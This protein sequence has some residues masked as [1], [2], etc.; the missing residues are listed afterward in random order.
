MKA[1]CLLLCT[2]LSAAAASAAPAHGR[3]PAATR[4]AAKP[5]KP[6][7]RVDAVAE[8]REAP[9]P[10]RASPGQV[11]SVTADAAFFDRG[12]ADGVTVGQELTF[13][14]GG[15]AAGKCT[16]A[17]V[18][19]HFARCATM[20]LRVGDRVGV[21]RGVA[22]APVAPAPLPSEAELLRRAASFDDATWRLRAFEGGRGLGA[23]AATRAELLVSHTTYG[24]LR[25]GN[26]AFGVQRLDAAVY[27]VELWRGLRASADVTVLNFSARP[28]TPNVGRPATRT[29]YQRSPVLL[30]RQLELSFRRA[31]VPFFAA[32]GRTWL[33]G[34]TG[35]MVLDGAQAGWRFGEGLELGAYGGLLPQAARLEVTPSQWAAG[36]FGRARFS[37][38]TGAG[39]TLGQLGVRAG[40]AQR[41]FAGEAAPVQRGEVTLTGQLWA[42]A[43]FDAATSLEFGFGDKMAPA[44]L[45][46]ARVDLGWRPTDAWRVVGGVRYRGLPL[47]G[48]VEVGTVSPGQRALHSDLGVQWRALE[49]LLLG[50]QGGFASDFDSRLLQARVGPEL[51]VPSLARLPIGLALAY[52]EELGWV[53]GRH[54]Y[55]QLNVAP[56]GLFRVLSRVSWFNQQRA[57]GSEGLEGHELG[58]T[59]ALEV[60]PWRYV[61]ARVLVMGRLPLDGE[62]QVLGSVGVQLG[63]AF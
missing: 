21:A 51:I 4:K 62:R 24:N 63:G 5:V 31:D 38:G 14:R 15:K 46:A 10:S 48:L 16:V 30:V 32:V 60:T 25:S 3:K 20:A 43:K 8:P 18:S 33:R 50:V 22:A 23:G 35:L 34:V 59:F 9:R 58:G 42:G 27:D 7:A 2:L 19:D 1:R 26:G 11:T 52:Q 47:T 41:E 12:S 28:T 29:E 57:T 61:N 6:P 36:A 37:S 13:T 45:D 39:A 56:L 40:F 55:F 53:R 44:A 54:A 17:A 49:G